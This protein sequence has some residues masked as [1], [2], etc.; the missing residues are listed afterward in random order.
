MNYI[1]EEELF[2]FYAWATPSPELQDKLD[3]MKGWA[4]KRLEAAVPAWA[5]P[6]RMPA[7]FK[8]NL[9]QHSPNFLTIHGN[10]HPKE[11]FYGLPRF[12]VQAYV[13]DWNERCRYLKPSPA[14]SMT[15]PEIRAM[16]SVDQ[17]W[18]AQNTRK[19]KT[20]GPRTLVQICPKYLVWETPGLPRGWMKFPKASEIIKARPGYLQ[21]R[22][23]EKGNTLTLTREAA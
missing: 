10:P 17:P 7:T 18:I 11:L 6:K 13:E 1:S 21:F 23:D 5:K 2:C 8:P 15:L 19:P 3:V 9:T 20:S 14:G 12:D 22:M 4:A 16:F